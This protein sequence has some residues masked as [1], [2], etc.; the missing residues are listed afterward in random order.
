MPVD[1]AGIIIV[2]NVPAPGAEAKGIII[3][4]KNDSSQV[5]GIIMEDKP[6]QD[7]SPAGIVIL[8]VPPPDDNKPPPDDSKA[9]IVWGG[10]VWG[11]IPGSD[12]DSESAIIIGGIPAVGTSS[13]IW[14]G[15]PAEE[16]ASSAIWTGLPAGFGLPDGMTPMMGEG[17]FGPM[18]FGQL[19]FEGESFSVPAKEEKCIEIPLSGLVPYLPGAGGDTFPVDSFFDVFT[20]LTVD[21]PKAGESSRIITRIDP[22]AYPICTST[23]SISTLIPELAT[24]TPTRSAS[25]PSPTPTIRTGLPTAV[26]GRIAPTNTPTP[27]PDNTRN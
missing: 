19:S 3:I 11:G 7:S 1:A 12:P 27:D 16:G 22:P 14:T 8:N 5:M 20:E 6:G 18:A 23:P 24:P 13:A 15:L 2:E 21:F 17:G 25:Q 9:G 26:P 4:N 10:I